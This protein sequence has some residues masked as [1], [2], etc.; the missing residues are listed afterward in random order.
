ML[1]QMFRKLQRNRKEV[2]TMS[3][4]TT[5]VRYICEVNSGLVQSAGFNDI[6]KI[7][8]NA[9]KDIDQAL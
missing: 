9:K 3:K 2:K 5:E 1:M 7:L 6:Q 4:Y 8:E